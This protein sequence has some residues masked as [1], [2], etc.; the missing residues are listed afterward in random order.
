MCNSVTKNHLKGLD[1]VERWTKSLHIL[2]HGY[3]GG[4]Y[5]GNNSKKILDNCEK[6]RQDLPNSL[7]CFPAIDALQALRKLCSGK[8]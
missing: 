8:M 3:N 4:G 1:A 7:D 6:L 2:R 5:D